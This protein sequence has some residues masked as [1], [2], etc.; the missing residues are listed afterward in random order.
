MN[1]PPPKKTEPESLEFQRQREQRAL[2]AQL[3]AW[4]E[5]QL[6]AESENDQ[7]GQDN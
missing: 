6:E 2:F 7:D 3:D 4:W 1:Q 5:S